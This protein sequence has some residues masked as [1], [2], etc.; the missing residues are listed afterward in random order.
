MGGT[1]SAETNVAENPQL[2]KLTALEIISDNDPFWNSL[3]SFNLKIDDDDIKLSQCN[4]LV[5]RLLFRLVVCNQL[6]L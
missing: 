3:F 6:S 5:F 4:K 1:I 2:L